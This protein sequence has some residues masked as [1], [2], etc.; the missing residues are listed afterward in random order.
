[1]K[2]INVMKSSIILLVIT[3]T[4]IG[5]GQSEAD[6]DYKNVRSE[7]TQRRLEMER[8]EKMGSLRKYVASHFA[9]RVDAHS[10]A[11]TMAD[12]KPAVT[13]SFTDGDRTT[14]S[15]L[16]DNGDSLL[17]YTDT[18]PT[19][20][21]E[22]ASEIKNQELPTDFPTLDT[23][24]ELDPSSLRSDAVPTCAGVS[25]PG[26]PYPCCNTNKGNC[27]FYAWHAAKQFW[28][29]SMPTWGTNGASDAKNWFDKSRASGLPTSA[30]P[31]LYAIAV[32][33]TLSSYGHVA[34]V[35]EIAGNMVLVF[36]QNCGSSANGITQTWR[37][38]STFNKGYVLSPINAPKPTAS[39]AT[40]GPLFKKSTDQ[41]VQFRVSNLNPGKR[42]VITFPDGG[43]WTLKD[44][45]LSSVQNGVLTAYM[46][47]SQR[48]TYK[49][50]FFNENGK[51]SDQA[52]FSVN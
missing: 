5:F 36:E 42:A 34:F 27:T 2:K 22:E 52:S 28:G 39:L 6:A 14:D 16:I 29:Y 23:N 47:L 51:Y 4:T 21:K 9:D 12:G 17:L 13:F 15:I 41:P 50:Q 44:G 26:N 20:W 49:I 48:G 45:Q 40:V 30:T 24:D 33:S 38:I 19:R 43:R 31:G 7:S 46:A 8:P 32:S 3:L 11:L 37:T 25:S 10:I 18:F 35:L 1:M